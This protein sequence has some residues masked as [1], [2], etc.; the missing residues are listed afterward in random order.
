[1]LLNGCAATGNGEK[2]DQLELE[3]NAA[4]EGIGCGATTALDKLDMGDS[5]AAAAAHSKHH[6]SHH[7]PHPHQQNGSE[8]VAAIVANGGRCA[9][10]AHLPK[11]K[12]QLKLEE[13]IK[14]AMKKMQLCQ[15]VFDFDDDD[16]N[17]DGPSDMGNSAGR[18][19]KRLALEEL[20]EFLRTSKG[21]IVSE[22]FY[23]ELFAMIG[24]NIFRDLPPTDDEINPITTEMP[25]SAPVLMEEDAEVGNTPDP[26]WPHLQ[27][28]YE[29]FIN[30]L[31]SLEFRA[32]MAKKFID[33][34]FVLRLIGLFQSEDPREREYLM[35]ILKRIYA[36]FIRLRAFIRK[37]ITYTILA[38][39]YEQRG[40]KFHGISELLDLLQCCIDDFK[41]PLK[42][43]SRELLTKVILPLHRQQ[44][45]FFAQYHNKLADRVVQFIELDPTLTG[46]VITNLLKNWPNVCCSKE[47]LFLE[48]IE[49]IL[50]ATDLEQFRRVAVPISQQI[51]KCIGSNHAQVANRALLLWKD[52]GRLNTF[53]REC[54]AQII[55]IVCSP[56]CTTAQCHWNRNVQ[57]LAKEMQ[58]RLAEMDWKVWNKAMAA[59]ENNNNNGN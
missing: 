42:A 10:L 32:T 35:K 27:L 16:D 9:E 34:G 53:L 48:E 41:I 5:A 30:F 54:S 29:I 45:R 39:I 59:I 47:L 20:N 24:R 57:T 28:I 51:A 55:P 36:K 22:R 46:P 33:T 6:H 14:L 8:M 49:R 31:C 4:I 44:N 25:S 52:D 13:R 26:A 2:I 23:A 3:F 15:T 12:D 40:Q 38:F 43:D 56:L 17:D 37:Q 19:A 58:N 7:H 1:M 18:E 50:C 11:I 21:A